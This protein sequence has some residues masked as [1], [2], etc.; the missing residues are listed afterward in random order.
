MQQKS[1]RLQKCLDKTNQSQ[2]ILSTTNLYSNKPGLIKG[3]Y[4][5]I[6][7]PLNLNITLTSTVKI[8]NAEYMIGYERCSVL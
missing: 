8:D 5:T 6:F 3:Q 4:V 2:F 7:S 1:Q